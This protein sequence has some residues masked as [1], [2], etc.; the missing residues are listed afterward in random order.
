MN[1]TTSQIE[2][3]VMMNDTYFIIVDGYAEEA[4]GAYLLEINEGA[5]P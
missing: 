5:C 3:D 4:A 2:L 1:L